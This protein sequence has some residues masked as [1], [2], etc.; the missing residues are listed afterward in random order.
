MSLDTGEQYSAARQLEVRL[1]KRKEY[2]KRRYWD[3]RTRV[4]IRR[5]E[6]SAREGGKPFRPKPRQLKLDELARVQAAAGDIARDVT[7]SGD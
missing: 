2:E 1:L 6:R 3:S 7:H 4:R 5:L